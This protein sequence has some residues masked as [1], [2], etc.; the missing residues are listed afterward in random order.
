[1]QI[2]LKDIQ[3]LPVMHS[4]RR[5]R[6]TDDVYFSSKYAKYI[7]NSKLKLINPNEGGS[8]EQY[9]G[10][11]KAFSTSSLAL[12]SA[13]HELLLQPEEFELG[14]KVGLPTAKKGATVVAAVQNYLKGGGLYE[15]IVKACK[16][17]DYYANAIDKHIKD[18]LDP[19]LEFYKVVKDYP[20]TTK[21]VIWLDDTTHDLC[22][23][24][25]TSMKNN[26]R[27]MSKLHPKD[28]FGDKIPSYNE[29]AIFCDFIAIYKDKAVLLPVKM[30]ADN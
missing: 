14:P 2:N 15:A 6:I 29:D 3:L 19:C 17:C 9:F 22:E 7:S 23:R 13:V 30:K 11:L 8:P 10:G 26:K 18:L 16:S 5:A 21:E 24:C 27:I 1:M 4:G 20:K 28:M 12:G 25:L